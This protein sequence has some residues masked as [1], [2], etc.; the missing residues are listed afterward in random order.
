MVENLVYLELRRRGYVV[1]IGKNQNKEIDFIARSDTEL[2]YIQVSW[3][4]ENPDTK[5][6]ELS[7]F[8]GLD[9]GYKKIL[10]FHG[11]RSLC[12]VGARV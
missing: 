1:D 11:Q 9:D 12:L 6:R 4:L 3:S 7:S 8:R 2:Y 10:N 5:Q